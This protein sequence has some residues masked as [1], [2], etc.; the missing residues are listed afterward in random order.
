MLQPWVF[1]LKNEIVIPA[2]QPCQKAK[3]MYLQPSVQSLKQWLLLSLCPQGVLSC[4]SLSQWMALVSIWFLQLG[5]YFSS[6][7][8]PP[9][10]SQTSRWVQWPASQMIPADHSP[11]QCCQP[12]WKCLL[13]L[14]HPSLKSFL[15]LPIALRRTDNS[16]TLTLGSDSPA[17]QLLLAPSPSLNNPY[18]FYRSGEDEGKTL[19]NDPFPPNLPVHES[20]SRFWVMFLDH[21]SQL[22]IISLL[23]MC[24]WLMR[25]GTKVSVWICFRDLYSRTWCSAWSSVNGL[26]LYVRGFFGQL[27]I[28]H[29]L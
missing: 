8:S 23:S 6:I 27:I 1:N 26:C 24:I 3:I 15:S 7:P 11:S 4:S 14:S 25:V 10:V 19:L 17:A 20:R 16:L 22:V 2:F 12:L 9:T 28:P 5:I 18:F 29:Y 13:F 21:L